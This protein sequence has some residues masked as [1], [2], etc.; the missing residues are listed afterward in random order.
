MTTKQMKPESTALSS[1]A[2]IPISK[3]EPLAFQANLSGMTIAVSEAYEQMP[4]TFR[5]VID[6]R[7]Q[8]LATLMHMVNDKKAH[9]ALWKM[10]KLVLDT[11]AGRSICNI[12]GTFLTKGYEKNHQ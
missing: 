10:Y 11:T 2:K 12:C 5:H 7:H 4:K 9:K 6:K 8:N 3:V 1:E